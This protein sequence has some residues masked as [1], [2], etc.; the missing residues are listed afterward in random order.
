MKWWYLAA[1]FAIL[2]VGVFI[3]YAHHQSVVEA[4][5]A[6][7]DLKSMDNESAA[8][9]ASTDEKILVTDIQ[10]AWEE[11]KNPEPYKLKLAKLDPGNVYV[12]NWDISSSADAV[13]GEKT[14]MAV[15]SAGHRRALVLQI[16]GKK[17]SVY[18]DT[19]HFLET[20]DRDQTG[21]AA[22]TYRLGSGRI[23]R[24]AW[25]ISNDGEALFYPGNAR[26]FIRKLS[27][28]GTLAVSYT[29]SDGVR[30]SIMFDTARLPQTF[31]R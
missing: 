4:S 14:T 24:Q 26:R 19:G 5:S 30:H 12:P 1:S 17:A 8:F 2:S 11:N 16:E 28:S 31:P 10:I 13:T 9:L 22:G 29:D 3:A 6:A 15:A 18:V 27:H 7:A 21:T 25:D 23:E 20:V